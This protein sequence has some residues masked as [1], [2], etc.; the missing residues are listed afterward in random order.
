MYTY[1]LKYPP[2]EVPVTVPIYFFF[3]LPITFIS[4]Q[5]QEELT[6]FLACQ[7][8]K[9]ERRSAFIVWNTPAYFYATSLM[10]FPNLIFRLKNSD[11][12]KD[13]LINYSP[14]FGLYIIAL[15]RMNL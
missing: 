2:V 12:K 10:S 7:L 3:H 4:R 8:F 15:R 1:T 5:E 9:A 13:V 6:T 14:V 11:A